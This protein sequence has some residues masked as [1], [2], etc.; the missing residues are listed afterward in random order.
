MT[1]ESKFNQPFMLNQ[2]THPALVGCIGSCDSRLTGTITNLIEIFHHLIHI[3]SNRHLPI[4]VR[5][6]TFHFVH[7]FYI[8][9]Q[10]FGIAEYR[11]SFRFYHSIPKDTIIL[12][13]IFPAGISGPGSVII[14]IHIR[15]TTSVIIVGNIVSGTC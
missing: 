6:R 7:R 13:H 3:T 2:F 10:Y 4:F 11:I 15:C 12:M 8:P 5:I 14:I 1:F 9:Q